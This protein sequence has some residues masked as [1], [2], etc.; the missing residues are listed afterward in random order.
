MNSEE[1]GVQVVSSVSD[2][3]ARISDPTTTKAGV[4]AAVRQLS[5]VR[6]RTLSYKKNSYGRSSGDWQDGIYDLVEISRAADTESL[7]SVSFRHHRE[8]LL[9]EGFRIKSKDSEA[10]R[11]LKSRLSEIESVSNRTFASILRE[12]ATDLIKFHSAFL[13]KRRDAARSS[14]GRIKMFGKKLDPIAALEPVDPT[15]MQVR[16]NKSGSIVQWRQFIPEQG[17]DVKFAPDE[18]ICITMD[19]KTGFIFGT[20]FCLP[21][22][23]DILT[24]RRL[25]ELVDVIA[26]KFAFPLVQY[27]VGTERMPAQEYTDENGGFYSEIDLVRDTLGNLPTE[28]SIVT[29]E[30]HEIIVL[31]AEGNVMDLQPYLNYFK[32]RV[33]A[34]LRLSGVEVGESDS[35]SKGSAVVITKNMVDAVKDYQE[36]LADAISF[37]LFREILLE[38]GFD[39]SEANQVHLVFAPVDQEEQRAKENHAMGLYQGHGVTQDE[40]R[41]RMD[42]EALTDEEQKRGYLHLVEI[43]LIEAKGEIELDKAKA[44]ANATANKTRPANQTGKKATKTKIKKNDVKVSESWAYGRRLVANEDYNATEAVHEALEMILRLKENDWKTVIENLVNDVNSTATN[45]FLKK[46]VKKEARRIENKVSTMSQTF[47]S[48]NVVDGLETVVQRVFAKLD[49]KAR[50]FGMLEAAREN[51]TNVMIDDQVYTDLKSLAVALGREEE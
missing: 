13:Y 51:E 5:R 14:G 11:I 12:I 16:Q 37:Y 8:L 10:L 48:L 7:L 43:P 35:T 28:G 17:E 31:G 32:G 27:K 19:K 6:P 29:S 33:M 3:K 9:K 39:V 44:S 22:L 34:G 47:D 45:T 50:A 41:D 25:E 46:I 40:M 1:T 42:M 4:N 49:I 20:P 30:R 26:T 21:V 18:I 36:V 23:D 15:S 38:E 24:L 2:L